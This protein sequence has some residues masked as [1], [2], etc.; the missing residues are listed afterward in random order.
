MGQEHVP[1]VELLAEL[2]GRRDRPRL[3][4]NRTVEQ[5]TGKMPLRRGPALTAEHPEFHGKSTIASE[6]IKAR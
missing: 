4:E 3:E 2:E 1:D 5:E 6:G